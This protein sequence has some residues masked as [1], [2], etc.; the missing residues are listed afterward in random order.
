MVGNELFLL[1]KQPFLGSY[2]ECFGKVKS[3]VLTC[4]KAGDHKGPCDSL[5]DDTY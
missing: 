5:N 1:L 3:I 2:D 4:M